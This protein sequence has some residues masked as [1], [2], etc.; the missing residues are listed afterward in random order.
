M[1]L[2]GAINLLIP[3]VIRRALNLEFEEVALNPWK[4]GI[5]VSSLFLIQAFFFAARSYL[6]ARIGQSVVARLRA[7][8]YHS[9]LNK[10]IE[11]FD[12]NRVGD[13]VSRIASDCGT[14][15][16]AV[17]ISA[18]VFIRYTLQVIGGVLLMV[19]IAPRL[20][21]IVGVVLLL[22]VA[23]SLL[24]AKRLRALSRMQQQQLGAA[25]S[26][27]EEGLSLIRIVR[28][29]GRES[30]EVARFTKSIQDSLNTGLSRATVSAL[31]SSS[32][33]LLLNLSM[34][35]ILIYGVTLV[36]GGIMSVGDLTAF[37]LYGGIVGISFGFAAESFPQ[38]THALG[39][40]SR[41]F[42]LLDSDDLTTADLP[43]KQRK[44]SGDV[45]FD[46][47]SFAYPARPDRQVLNQISFRIPA[48]KTTAL[49]GASGSGKTTLVNLILGFYAPLSGK[50][51][52]GGFDPCVNSDIAVMRTQI[53][54][55][56]QE[57]ILFS[58]SIAENL[59]YGAPEA[60]ADQLREVSRKA[61]ILDFIEGLPLKFDTI[62]GERGVQLSGGQRQRLAIARA[63]LR[64]PA[65][66]I[67]DEATSSLDAENEALVQ[68][69]LSQL[70]SNRTSIV[71]A[72]RLS[73]I[74]RAD[75][76]V[77]LAQGSV[78]SEGPP[79]QVERDSEFYR[80]MLAQGF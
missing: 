74:R 23:V 49:V 67:L 15:Q 9:I 77:V 41:V 73:S 68:E 48:G 33:N 45:V 8:L 31:F 43:E 47:V 29:F 21:L 57:P 55:V 75:H 65:L 3:E 36:T 13:L 52:V 60:S 1:V 62:V 42:D 32:V 40:S 59:S 7:D 79:A 35:G 25:H 6:F 28:A 24:F 5:V 2:A 30:F 10:P 39:A 53:S 46:R 37:L 72:H 56:P 14:I 78:I 11:F 66:L 80:T 61:Q 17:S 18:S 69:A 64:D 63:M 70:M 16:D 50:I 51:S 71:I 44:L 38:F 20:T 27:A 76:L 58:T 54:V 19:F 26:T 12:H 4:P 34:V 22:L